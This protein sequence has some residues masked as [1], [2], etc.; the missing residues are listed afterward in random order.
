MKQVVYQREENDVQKTL[1]TY[2]VFVL[3]AYVHLYLVGDKLILQFQNFPPV[4]KV[5]QL[6]YAK[7]E[8]IV[9]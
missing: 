9:N 7:K 6:Y 1:K 4:E 5:Q 8:N 3:S 2:S